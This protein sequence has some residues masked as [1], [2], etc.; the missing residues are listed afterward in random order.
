VDRAA[1]APLRCIGCHDAAASASHPL[2]DYASV[3]LRDPERFVPPARL[4]REV[5]L[6]GGKI[7]CT[8]CHDGASRDPK[9]VAIAA[10]LCESCH[11]L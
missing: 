4:A 11:Q 7:A 10:R 9:H 6:V 5:P 1:A 3:A 2:V 8:S